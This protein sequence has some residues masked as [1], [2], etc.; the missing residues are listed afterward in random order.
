MGTWG[1]PGADVGV[2]IWECHINLNQEG[3]NGLQEDLHSHRAE[4][5][6]SRD[7]GQSQA[8]ESPCRAL[9]PPGTKQHQETQACPLHAPQGLLVKPFLFE[10][11][12]NSPFIKLPF[13]PVNHS[14][15]SS[16]QCKHGN[17]P[18]DCTPPVYP[19]PAGIMEGYKAGMPTHLSHAFQPLPMG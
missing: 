19:S 14:L 10:V 2:S 13:S 1:A 4:H 16:F 15:S 6:S 7:M 5:G 18:S 9:C 17:V 12:L 3:N 11:R 8:G